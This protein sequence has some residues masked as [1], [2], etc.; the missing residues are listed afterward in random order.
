MT[1]LKGSASLSLVSGPET[2]LNASSE[3]THRTG[4]NSPFR[5]STDTGKYVDTRSLA[6][7]HDGAGNVSVHDELDARA[8]RSNIVDERVMAGSV[9]N[10]HG[11]IGD[12][13]TLR[14]GNLLEVPLDR[15]RD[16]DHVNTVRP[17]DELLHV[18]NRAGIEHRTALGYRDDGDSVG[19]PFCCESCAV[20]WVDRDIDFC[21]AAISDALPVEQHWCSV[22]LALT[23]DDDPVHRDA[24]DQCSHRVHC[25]TIGA[26][27]VS[28]A[29][30]TGR[31][32]G[33]G[34]GDPDE[35][36]GQ[37]AIWRL[38]GSLVHSFSVVSRDGRVLVIRA[39]HPC[40]PAAPL[41]REAPKCRMMTE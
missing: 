35:L 41:S 1:G 13:L 30:P 24:A 34:F 4:S 14:S 23:D 3:T 18:E 33:G 12:P 36:E 7:R 15:S 26:V 40:C 11:Q 22:L 37:V 5:S 25:G 6:S 19:H 38:G 20:D 29:N 8:G 2:T 39:S 17:D 21:T 10:A 16:V 9:E 27:L 32:H 31:G 28:T